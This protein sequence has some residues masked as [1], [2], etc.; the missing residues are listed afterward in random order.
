MSSEKNRATPT[1]E[2]LGERITPSTATFS[3]GMLIVQGDNLGNTIRVYADSNNVI[4]VSERGDEVAIAGVQPTT[5]NT[6]IIVQQAGKG[7]N[8]TLTAEAT[9]GTIPTTL[10]GN[11]SGLMTFQPLNAAPSTA[12]GSPNPNAVNDFI[13]GPSADVFIGGSG[14]NL[15]DWQPG[16]GTDTY[17]GAGKSNTVFV[18][19]NNSGK[20]EI[21][22]LT[23]DGQGGVTYSRENVVPFKLFTSGIQNWYITPSNTTG[24]LVTIKDLSDT[25][26]KLI[27]VNVNSSTVDAVAQ[28]NG[29]VKLV[30][31]GTR[32]T[33]TQGEGPTKFIRKDFTTSAE[34]VNALLAQIK[35]K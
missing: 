28:N 30:V 24:N 10:I 1:L 19:G 26:T 3:N 11:G 5:A 31:N 7:V 6:R 22:T 12:F 29:N 32:N 9:L 25:P 18:V 4:H 15:F 20:P 35:K 21:D 23:A 27:Q 34:L 16:T 33:V 13:S 8:N 2:N 17:V 14:R